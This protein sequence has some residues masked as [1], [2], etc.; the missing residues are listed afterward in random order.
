[1]SSPRL[2]RF[3][4]R[5]TPWFGLPSID[6]GPTTVV[7]IVKILDNGNERTLGIVVDAVSEV[8]SLPLDEADL[9]RNFLVKK[10]WSL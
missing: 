9:H 8:Y 5:A 4:P 2:Y 1:M 7:I 10:T 6:F 3:Y